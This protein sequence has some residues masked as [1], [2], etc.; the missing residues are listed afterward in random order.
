MPFAP[1]G[2]GD[3]S[4]ARRR[5]RDRPDQDRDL[6]GRQRPGHAHRGRAHRTT[7][8]QGRSHGQVGLLL[9]VPVCHGL[10][11][12][13]AV[14]S[15][16]EEE[17]AFPGRADGGPLRDEPG[18]DAGGG[19]APWLRHRDRGRPDGRR[20]HRIDGDRNRQRY[21]RPA[22]AARGREDETEEQH[23]GRLCG[24]LPG[25]HRIR[26]LVSVGRGATTASRRH[27]G[28]EQET[29]GSTVGGRPSRTR[30]FTWPTRNGA[31][32]PTGWP[33]SRRAGPSGISS[34]PR[35][36]SA[37][38]WN[39]SGEVPSSSRPRRGPCC[40]RAMSSPSGRGAE[41]CSVEACRLE[42]KSRTPRFS[43]FR[44]RLSTWW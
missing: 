24:Q 22:R 5:L 16:L 13:T 18:D 9:A 29:G 15:R 39:A 4:D 2:T 31:F 23:P 30:K 34:A 38:S 20:V 26:R 8:H 33:T 6:Q 25:G 10:Q 1:P 7:R 21:D 32:V 3:L 17:R 11:G 37:S 35:A 42:R 36:P 12:R 19:E 44:W 40:N 28:R 43:S 41:C 27:E 14:L